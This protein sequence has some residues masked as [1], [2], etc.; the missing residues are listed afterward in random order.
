MK[1]LLLLPLLLAGGL[2]FTV[3]FTSASTAS[4]IAARELSAASD[5][6]AGTLCRLNGAPEGGVPVSLA[7]T[8]DQLDNARTIIEVG[9]GA[10]VS[11]YGMVIAIATAMQEST[12]KN[13]DYGDRD[14]LGLFQQRPS[15]GWGTREQ[16]LDPALSSQAFY[17]VAAHTSNPGL[18][19]IPG[20]QQMRVTDAAQAVQR[21]GFPE[22]YQQWEPLGRQVVGGSVVC[23]APAPGVV[24]DW[25]APMAAGTYTKTSPFGMRFHPIHKVY[26][27][28]SGT[29]LAAPTG[30][31]VYAAAGGTV[32]HHSSSGVGTAIT[33]THAGGVATSYFHLNA[34]HVANGQTVS[35][36][37]RIA[38]VGN[39]GDSTGAHLHFELRINGNPIDPIPYLAE[40]GITL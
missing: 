4:L 23:E 9:A 6:P 21:S 40:R 39:T 17:G 28:H 8:M 38:D 36:G 26:R 19:D 11:E 27:L 13:I 10:S 34:R 24:G 37:E 7:L 30:T 15:Q 5:S 35:A 29:D 32:R 16:I 3:A 1:K 20:W 2:G 18:L 33:I 31:P 25:S 22:A 14:S 12:L